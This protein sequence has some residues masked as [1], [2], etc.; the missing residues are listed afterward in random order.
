MPAKLFRNLGNG[1]FQDVTLKS[2]IG[3]PGPGLGVIAADFNG[4]G[5]IDIYV[6]NDGAANRLWINKG[7]GTFEDRALV[8]GVAYS[9]EGATQAG[10]GVTA[11]DPLNDDRADLL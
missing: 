5:L 3:I 1:K 7:D 6:A 9:T 10:M 4:D 2:G 11:G 8:A